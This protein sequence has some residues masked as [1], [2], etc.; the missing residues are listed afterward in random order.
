[1]GLTVHYSL[2]AQGD[3]AHARTI[4]NAMH[5]AAQDLPFEYLGEILDLSGDQCDYSK[6]DREDPLRWL[7]IQAE[8]KAEIKELPQGSGSQPCVQYQRI[9]PIQMV[10]FSSWPGEG[11]EEANFGLCRYPAAIETEAGRLDTRLTGWQWSSYCKTQYASDPGCGGL[12]NFLQCHLSV[13]ALLDKAKE[14]GCLA[15]VNDEGG[16]WEKRN[17]QQLAQ[18]V[19]SWNEMLAALA[20]K[21]QDLAGSGPAAIEAPIAGYADFERLEAAGQERLPPGFEKLADLI[22]RVT[23]LAR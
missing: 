7:L 22:G 14:L 20:G 1:M 3:E 11:C 16:F 5:Q 19:G 10:A 12:P 13:I 2:K 15:Q 23:R 6:R 21:L 4:I 17:V 18:Q 9:R 8:A